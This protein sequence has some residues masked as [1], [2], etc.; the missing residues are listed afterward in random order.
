MYMVNENTTQSGDSTMH[1]I[2]TLRNEIIHIGNKKN[3]DKAFR[4]YK[5]K[6]IKV[7]KHITTRTVKIGELY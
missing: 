7:E 6:G 5:K 3:N 2:L 1:Y 4:S